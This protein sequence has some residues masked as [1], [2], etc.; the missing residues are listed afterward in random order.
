MRARTWPLAQEN[1]KNVQPAGSRMATVCPTC[2]W[3]ALSLAAVLALLMPSV[4][5]DEKI[6]VLIVGMVNGR[7]L[8]EKYL[9]EEPSVFFVSVPCRAGVVEGDLNVQ[10]KYIRQYFPRTYESMR[11]FDLIMLHSPE[12]YFLSTKQDKW[13][14]DRIAEGAGGYNDGSV[15][16]II[17]QI[18][19]SWANSL[20]QQAFPNDAPAVVARGGGGESPTGSYQ[21]AINKDYPDPVLTPFIPFGVERVSGLVSRFVIARQRAGILAYQLGSFPGHSK[22]PFLV[23]WDYGKA[24]TMTCGGF[25][26]PQ[27]WFGDN[28]LY[29]SDIVMN[30]IFYVA[31]KPLI[32]DVATFH[33]L[34]G[35]MRDF[36]NRRDFLVSMA[37]FVDKLGANTLRIQK[38]IWDLE[39]LWKSIQEKYLEHDF[40]G[41]NE[42][43]RQSV[44]EFNEAEA[45]AKEV[46]NKAM[47]WI[48]VTEWVITASVFFISSFL[49]TTLMVRRRLYRAVTTTKM[50]EA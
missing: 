27:S 38:K 4:M 10:M 46:K 45:L 48:Y 34:K 23:A 14:Y 36:T 6:K 37:D 49:I 8:T 16:S 39:D 15:F 40:Q 7:S 20:A 30:M 28:N 50:K 31:Q 5:G 43:L 25:I 13:I 24:K 3:K 21:V 35:R 42:L 47:L 29:G 9:S 1:F 18:H 19:D 32:D 11:T 44:T 17:S 12:Y 26:F 22:V 41:C 2:L 33:A